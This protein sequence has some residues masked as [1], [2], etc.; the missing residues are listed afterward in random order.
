[1]ERKVKQS[2]LQKKKDN[3]DS[4]YWKNKCDGEWAKQ[5]KHRD[6]N[7][8]A[9]C[10][11]EENLHTHHLIDRNIVVYRHELWNGI[12]L[13]AKHHMYDRE[14]SA[15]KATIGFVFWLSHARK[16]AYRKVLSANCYI[17]KIETYRERFELMQKSS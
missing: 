17:K 2:K 6:S 12:T 5:I 9:M 14:K 1:M 11:S 7:K 15:H 4:K 8:C 13:C 16:D 10:G 3:P